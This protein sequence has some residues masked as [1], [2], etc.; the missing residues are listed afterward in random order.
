M[1]VRWQLV[2]VFESDPGVTHSNPK[3]ITIAAGACFPQGDAPYD[4][5][6]GSQNKT[7]LPHVDAVKHEISK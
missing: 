6:W 1:P 5:F 2:T 7:G 4:F 3:D